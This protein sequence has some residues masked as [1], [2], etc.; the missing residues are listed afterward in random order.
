MRLPAFDAAPVVI[1]SNFYAVVTTKP[2]IRLQFDAVRL[3]FDAMS[4]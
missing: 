2:T 3:P 4:L 1:S